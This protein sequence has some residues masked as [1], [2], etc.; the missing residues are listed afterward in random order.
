MSGATSYKWLVRAA[1][2]VALVP[3]LST[4]A[5]ASSVPVTVPVPIAGGGG[6]LGHGAGSAGMGNR[7]IEVNLTWGDD[8]QPAA[9]INSGQGGHQSGGGGS[10]ISGGGSGGGGAGAQSDWIVRQISSVNPVVN[11]IVN[12]GAG[13]VCLPQAGGGFYELWYAP[14]AGQ[15]TYVRNVCTAP[16]PA[17]A[18]APAGTLGPPLPPPPPPPPPPSLQEIRA[19]VDFPV[20]VV[21][22]NPDGDGLTGLE[23]WCWYGGETQVSVSTSLRGYTITGSAEAV[24]FAWAMG[25]GA[26]YASTGPGS[27]ASPAARHTYEA[28]DDYALGLTVAWSGTFAFSGF[29]ISE[30][31]SLGEAAVSATRPYHVVEVR[32]VRR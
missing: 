18:G 17:P 29:G 22:V 9:V 11:A 16:G 2:G 15:P 14:A 21:G 28:K 4:Q 32:A 8:G 31:G 30:S 12:P 23:T 6:G 7:G 5:S 13:D 24:R 26:T 27:E 25:D 19:L 1:I 10:T 3:A 20:P